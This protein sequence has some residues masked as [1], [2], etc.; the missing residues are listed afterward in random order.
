MSYPKSLSYV[1]TKLANYSR[2]SVKVYPVN[3]VST[4]PSSAQLQIILPTNTI[5]DLD[6]L[7][8]NGT[9]SLIGSTG[10]AN[11]PKFIESVIDSSWLEV[12]G[13]I[14]GSGSTYQNVLFKTLMDFVGEDTATRRT[15]LN[16]H[17]T[18]SYTATTTYASNTYT[19]ALTYVPDLYS[20]T[21]LS[22]GTPFQISNWVGN[23][24][25]G[26]RPRYLDTSILPDGV[27]LVI[28]LASPA[29]LYNDGTNSFDYQLNNV[30]VTCDCIAIQDGVY[31]ELVQ[32]RLES[33]PIEMPFANWFTFL[34]N[35][36]SSA[37]VTRFGLATGSLDMLIGAVLPKDY[38]TQAAADANIGTSV[39]FKRG[40][41]GGTDLTGATIRSYF[42]INNV[43]Q[44]AYQM[45]VP[46]QYR[47]TLIAFGLNQEV[48]QQS[49]DFGKDFA[50]TSTTL[51]RDQ[52][53]LTQ[54]LQKYYA[55]AIRFN[56]PDEDEG[57]RLS[58]IDMRGTNGL[59]QWQLFGCGTSDTPI[60]FAKCT[61]KLIIGQGRQCVY[62]A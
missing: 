29:I 28:R 49:A 45:S 61:S 14:V 2:S 4:V 26:L 51:T 48:I 62:E 3:L 12:G 6:S 55:N 5:I 40:I 36:G 7:A 21:T 53:Y 35:S 17:I 24:L 56:H 46:D 37:P 57:T 38:A 22:T 54:W 23:A 33:S 25:G 9:W 20:T 10:K 41:T 32:K 58:G 50:T 27:R 16:H 42:Q 59:V 30:Y 39:Y 15:P 47:Q 11:F 34:G 52:Y 8:L 18:S 1:C 44:P 19:T 43:Q 13:Q 60:V 31:E